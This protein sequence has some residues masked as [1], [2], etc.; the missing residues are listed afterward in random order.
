MGL[1]N[2]NFPM[3]FFPRP[4]YL[5]VIFCLSLAVRLVFAL[6]FPDFG[7]DADIYLRV[8]SNII[9]GCGVAISAVDSGTCVPH[10]GGNQGPGYPLF[11]AVNWMLFDNSNT[12]VRFT[13]SIIVC[14]SVV[15]F[16]RAI[17]KFL[18]S[19]KKAF[20]IGCVLAISPCAIAWSRFLQT[21]ALSLAGTL[22]L[23]AAL[24]LSIQN[25]K[26]KLFEISAAL[27]FTS[28]IRLDAIA[29]VIPICYTAFCI[30]NV[31]KAF[32]NIIIIGLIVAI[33]WGGWMIR[34]YH[35]GLS[36]VLPQGMTTPDGG[37]E[38]T[39]Y[40]MWIRTW[41]T[42][43]YHNTNSQWPINRLHYSSASIDPE[44][45]ISDHERKSVQNLLDEL[46]M[47]DGQ[48]F[49]VH[50]DNEFRS[51]AKK[52]ITERPLE[53][54]VINPLKRTFSMWSNP[55]NSF[56]WPT[57]L[58]GNFSK[59][60]RIEIAKGDLGKLYQVARNNI[61]I[62]VNKAFI[63]FWRIGFLL[64]FIYFLLRE[65]LKNTDDRFLLFSVVSLIFGKS[66]I[67][68]ALNPETRYIM[69]TI[70][71][72]EASVISCFLRKHRDFTWIAKR[73]KKRNGLG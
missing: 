66:L 70:P 22:W 35:V 20:I 4:H 14:M 26:L 41:M 38:P 10:F 59:L 61:M 21:E 3:F 65:F 1:T 50:I 16:V 55:F 71:L 13:Q 25:R 19:E 57:M 64:A 63:A 69:T 23:F 73:T 58:D 28:F 44:I 11:I 2:L 30:S 56:G 48:S 42:N 9:N 47:F 67:A 72:I 12:V 24:L 17:E 33:P 5:F 54:F 6:K 36:S 52:R 68:G 40:L 46:A 53:V 51:L 43:T 31:G 32:K 45:F 7:G 8:A 34:N 15:Y 37:A 62:A 18:Q 39:G 27:I 29:L 60:L 49:P